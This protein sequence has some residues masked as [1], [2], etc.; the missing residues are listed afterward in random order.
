[1]DNMIGKTGSLILPQGRSAMSRKLLRLFLS[2]AL[3]SGV[4]VW[5][6]GIT[7][8]NAANLFANVSETGTLNSGSGV[9]SVT[10]LFTG[11]YEVTFTSP[12]SACAY[13][14]TT[15]HST[16]QALTV[17]T[18]G[19]HLSS[20]GVYVETK[21]QGG[22]LN[23]G[24]FNLVVVCGSTGMQYAV[25]GYTANLVRATTGA[26][27]TPLGPGRYNLTFP[28]LVQPCAYLATV[29]DPANALV[30]NPSGVYTGSGPNPN[31]VYI[32]TKNP[33]GGLSGGVPFHL[34]VVCK[35][36][37]NANIAVVTASG[38][39]IRGS[40]L[41]S[42]FNELPGKYTVV[43]KRNISK[44]ATIATR[45]SANTAVP[46]S[47]ATVEVELVPGPGVNT[48]DI[49]VRTLLFFGGTLFNQA[50]HTAMVCP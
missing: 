2:T 18:A 14:A 12:V 36:A 11:Q 7:A 49:Q 19:G 26:S 10:K 16:S 27:L 30:F 5:S 13:V 32:E 4:L 20:N 15:V 29:G 47:P 37:A 3:L 24:P 28:S 34:A 6:G 31:T 1:M 48:I 44:C 8:A 17:F 33:G 46:F 21:N 41:T 38:I 50:F 42:S 23:D 35:A 25:V 40:L 45:G 43:T 9:S 39:P 22:G